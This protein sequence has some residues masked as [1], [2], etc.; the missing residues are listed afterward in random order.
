[1]NKAERIKYLNDRLYNQESFHYYG[2]KSLFK[3]RP[4]DEHTFPMLETNTLFL[5]PASKLDDETECDT[6]ID[7]SEIYELE[8]NNL[9]RICIDKII[10]FIKPYCTDEVFE[11][12]RNKIYAV[13][14]RNGITR[15][16][17]LLDLAPE[18]QQTVPGVDVYPLINWLMDIPREL[19]KPEIKPQLEQLVR[20]AISAKEDLG[21]C[22]LSENT[23]IQYMW[24]KYANNYSGYCIEYDAESYELNDTIFPVIYDARRD[25]NIVMSI[26]GNF[27]G[28]LV[29]SFSNKQVQADASQYIRLFLSKYPEW[30]Y[31]NEW[32]I[33]GNAGTTPMAPKIKRI[34]I[35][36]NAS[37]ENVNN[38]IKYCSE[39]KIPYEIKNK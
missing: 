37:N 3:Y 21:I 19:D 32:R 10:S 29:T 1:M 13:T 27:I 15:N 9:K 6:S 17:F 26:V 33:L 36:Q 35:G 20:I 34:I 11:E 18:I 12:V 5:C 23:D 39:N 30:E 24:E 28:Q 2:P 31:Q 25:T 16:H 38:I 4:F 8:T 22:S 7:M 14:L